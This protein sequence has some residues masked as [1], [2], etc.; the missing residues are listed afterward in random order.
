MQPKVLSIAQFKRNL[1]I[2]A[3]VASD[4]DDKAI[5]RQSQRRTLPT[6]TETACGRFGTTGKA[7]CTKRLNHLI[8]LRVATGLA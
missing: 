5:F 7:A 1:F 8:N 6:A 3:A 4:P 2:L